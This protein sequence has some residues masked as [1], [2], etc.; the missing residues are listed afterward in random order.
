MDCEYLELC[1]PRGDAKITV[2]FFRQD[3]QGG[4]IFT[5]SNAITKLSTK[6]LLCMVNAYRDAFGLAGYIYFNIKRRRV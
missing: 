6:E 4:H 2:R 5:A 3:A 1:L